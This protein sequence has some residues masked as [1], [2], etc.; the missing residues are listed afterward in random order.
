MGEAGMKLEHAPDTLRG[1]DVTV[2]RTERMPRGQGVDGWLEGAADLIVEVVEESEEVD[3]VKDRARSFLRAGAQ[4]VWV[5]DP[6]SNRVFVIAS[7]HQ[8]EELNQTDMLEGGDLLPGFACPV[9]ELF[10]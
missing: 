1:A 6:N 7:Q 4:M 9:A 5:V 3:D 10:G 8:V 2:I